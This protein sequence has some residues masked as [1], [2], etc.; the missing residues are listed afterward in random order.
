MKDLLDDEDKVFLEHK[1]KVRG[2]TEVAGKGSR[3]R[4]EDGSSASR[5]V[6]EVGA[7]E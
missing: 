5:N 2:S 6:S 3:L 4:K 1:D 7:E